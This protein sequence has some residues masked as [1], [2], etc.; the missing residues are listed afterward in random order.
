MTRTLI[1]ACCTL[2]SLTACGRNHGAA[3]GPD[4]PGF[5][6]LDGAR[7]D[8]PPAPTPT[9]TP[10]GPVY[11]ESFFPNGTNTVPA[12]KCLGFTIVGNGVTFAPDAT[13]KVGTLGVL[14]AAAIDATHLRV[15]S[16]ETKNTCDY[17]PIFFT[18]TGPQDV[19]ITSGTQVWTLSSALQLTPTQVF[20]TGI[21]GQTQV[22]TRDILTAPGA[23]TFDTP[24]D[25]DI[26]KVD[27][28]GIL[29]EYS[30]MDFFDRS[31]M[32]LVPRIEFWNQHWPNT[33]LGFGAI[34]SIFPENGPNYFVV[35]DV[36]GKGGPGADY[37]LGASADVLADP[38]N[39]GTGCNGSHP[40]LPG[41]YHVGDL[42]LW[43]GFDPQGAPGCSDQLFGTPIYA[44]GLDATWT[45]TVPAGKTLRAAAYDNHYS[46]AIYL[47]PK[48]FGCNPHPTTCTAA[49]GYFGG[50]STNQIKYT[51]RSGADEDFYLVFDTTGVNGIS[52][53]AFFIN[54]EM[55]DRE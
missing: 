27:T 54:I 49:A 22:Y 51:N 2:L 4:A 37:D 48:D 10:S 42:H 5:P 24:Y 43:N 14:T 17:T 34:T 30:H 28:V 26:Y 15:G 8:L 13:V 7:G 41:T 32:S 53:R 35:R 19:T 3:A 12:G 46:Q 25:V 21:V 11:L 44:S 50:G 55:L 52:D 31:G 47:L 29:R 45:I 38:G 36:E 1:L 16:P 33:F 18:K 40:I 9:P 39:D 23:N 20:E 6:A